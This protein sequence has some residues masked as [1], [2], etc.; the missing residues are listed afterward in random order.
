MSSLSPFPQIRCLATPCHTQDSICY[1]VTPS[2]GSSH[3]GGVFTGDTLFIAG[4]GR[5]FEGTAPEMHAAL[6]YLGTLP[7]STITYNG[8]EYTS[9]SLRFGQHVDPENTG[10]K[11]LAEIVEKNAHTTGLTTIG[12]EK[13]WNVFMRLDS[14]AVRSVHFTVLRTCLNSC[15]RF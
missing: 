13:E 12:D 15:A 1:H 2:D 6:S 14:D 9:A 10:L 5:F 11:R 7:G 3:P 8:H 4:C